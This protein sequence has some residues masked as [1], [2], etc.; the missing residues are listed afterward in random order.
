MAGDETDS[1]SD[2]NPGPDERAHS[3]DPAGLSDGMPPRGLCLPDSR[4]VRGFLR[5]LV[6]PGSEAMVYT[7]S[8]SDV[9][10][11]SVD[12]DRAD[13]FASDFSSDPGS[14]AVEDFISDSD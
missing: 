2:D 9:G 14:D 3:V 1:G 6:V 11:A 12:S 5:P 7:D 4:F 8:G 10:T 13:D